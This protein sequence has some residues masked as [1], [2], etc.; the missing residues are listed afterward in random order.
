MGRRAI[1]GY[2]EGNDIMGGKNGLVIIGLVVAVVGA[3]AIAIPA[4]TTSHTEEVAK[5]GDLKLTNQE[6]T[7]HYIPSYVGPLALGLGVILIGV[8]VFSRR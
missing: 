6:E 2:S 3:L 5:V 7:T 8:G 1:G 4:F